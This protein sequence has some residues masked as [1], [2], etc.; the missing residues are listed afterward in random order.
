MEAIDHSIFLQ[1]PS[2]LRDLLRKATIACLTFGMTTF[3]QSYA[4]IATCR[5]S[6]AL[7][8]GFCSTITNE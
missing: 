1:R 2:C 5:V 8:D 3:S 6:G 4:I 7:T